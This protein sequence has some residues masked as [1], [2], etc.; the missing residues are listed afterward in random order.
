MHIMKALAATMLLAAVLSAGCSGIEMGAPA[1][2]SEQAQCE[3]QR[4]AGVW[5]AAAGACIRGG[6]AM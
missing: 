3:Q 1:A 4:G 2:M 6:G 5:V